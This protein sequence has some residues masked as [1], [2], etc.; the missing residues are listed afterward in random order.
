MTINNKSERND[1]GK[2]LSWPI[3]SYGP[4]YGV[5]SWHRIICCRKEIN[6]FVFSSAGKVN[7][8][9]VAMILFS[10]Y[11]LVHSKFSRQFKIEINQHWVNS[12][13]ATKNFNILFSLAFVIFPLGQYCVSCFVWSLTGFHLHWDYLPG[14]K[15]SCQGG[16]KC[17]PKCMIILTISWNSLIAWK[18]DFF[19]CAANCVIITVMW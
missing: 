10:R 12:Y 17:M 11:I 19:V 6:S 15:V 7:I 2:C 14:S 1:R 5:S 18:V 8:Y 4:G 3:T 13:W 9:Q 16:L